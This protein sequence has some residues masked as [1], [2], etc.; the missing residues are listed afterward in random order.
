MGFYLK[1]FTFKVIACLENGK[2]ESDLLSIQEFAEED[3]KS[4]AERYAERNYNNR[5]C[6]VVHVFSEMVEVT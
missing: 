6:K 1:M 3:A 2:W 5:G 4:K